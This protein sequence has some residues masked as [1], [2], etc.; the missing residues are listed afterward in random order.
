MKIVLIGLG[1]IGYAIA[2]QMVGEAH[3]LTIVDEN[4]AA[5]ERAGNMLDA[6]CVEGNGAAASVLLSLS[7]SLVS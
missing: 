3:D 6:M 7:M 2:S 5:L 4:A 1:K